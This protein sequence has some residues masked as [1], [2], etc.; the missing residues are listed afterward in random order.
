MFM[1]GYR[2]VFQFYD[3][4]QRVHFTRS[5]ACGTLPTGP[6]DARPSSP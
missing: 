3:K 2:G 6:M 1:M 5:N 4:N